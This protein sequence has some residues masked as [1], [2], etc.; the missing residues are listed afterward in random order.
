MGQLKRARRH[1]LPAMLSAAAAWLFLLLS[2]LHP[3]RHGILTTD[4]AMYQAMG[5]FMSMGKLP[6]AGSFDNKGPLLYLINWAGWQIQPYYGVWHIELLSMAGTV[7]AL[8]KTACRACLSDGIIPAAAAA[9]AMLAC[10]PLFLDGNTCEEYLMLPMA[11]SLG[12]FL[13]YAQRKTV[14]MAKTAMCGACFGAA[15]LLKF[16]AAALW[17]VGC[18]AIA[19]HCLGQKNTRRLA[20]YAACFAA[21]AAA[22]VLPAAI[23]LHA[24]GILAPC[25]DSYVMFNAHYAA[26][27]EHPRLAALIANIWSPEFLLAAAMLACKHRRK[28]LSPANAALICAMLLSALVNA[29]PGR[30]S[31]HYRLAMMPAI[32]IRICYFLSSAGMRKQIAG[33][34]I[35]AC[36]SV[37]AGQAADAAIQTLSQQ[38][39]AMPS[40]MAAASD[41]L[42]ITEPGD[43]IS[44]YG[45]HSAL[46]TLSARTHATRYSYQFPVSDYDS[47]LLPEY[48]T[49]LA[50]EQP[51]AIIVQEYRRDSMIESFLAQN[52][53]AEHARHEG[54]WGWYTFT[55]YAK[56]ETGAKDNAET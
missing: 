26:G 14:G 28:S 21:G 22:A 39:D 47:G 41:I 46:Y 8:Y 4:G 40:T 19:L 16:S 29:M 9:C 11:I 38:P 56:P 33:I 17:A 31:P 18:C 43:T 5:M 49:Q 37:S 27:P 50:A 25:W 6:Y 53:Y 52:G 24:N 7:M 54:D 51:A 34:V 44:V 13:E 23:W 2:P 48:F 32:V 10:A 3:A 15:L 45:Y 20:V 55:I 1:V 42:A 30:I 35:M 12:I 36:F